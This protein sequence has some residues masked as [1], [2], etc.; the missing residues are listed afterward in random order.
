MRC[1]P[2]LGGAGN[3]DEGELRGYHAMTVRCMIPNQAC[4][5]CSRPPGQ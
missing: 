1:R 4:G 5:R 2:I 3:M